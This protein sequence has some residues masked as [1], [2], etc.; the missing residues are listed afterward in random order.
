MSESKPFL[1][2]IIPAYNEEKRI[3]ATLEAICRYM[4]T[5]SF[6]W[7]LIVVLDGVSDNTLDQ[8][9]SFA[10]GKERICWIDRSENRGKGYTVREGMLSVKGK[11]RLFMD[12]DNSTDISHFDLMMPLFE[13]GH[14]VVICSRDDKDAAGA[15]QTVP[16]PF[17]KRVLGNVGNLFIQLVAVPGIWDTQCGFK[18]FTAEAADRIFSVSLIDR[19]GFDIEAMA[20]ARRFGYKTAIVPASWID[21]A[22]TH[23]T[24]GN[25]LGTVIETLRVRWHLITGVYNHALTIVPSNERPRLSDN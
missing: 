21:D 11:I 22:E 25:Y 12:A 20:L 24:L 6:D 14:D 7:D 17:L 23:V 10:A 8:I 9:E 2:V 19:W 5:Q 1:S 16:Q 3:T 18:A 13:K 4:S 15:R